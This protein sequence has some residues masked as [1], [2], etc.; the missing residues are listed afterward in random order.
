MVNLRHF[1]IAALGSVVAVLS[2]MVWYQHRQLELWRGTLNQ[3]TD[4]A[5]DAVA[6][7]PEPMEVG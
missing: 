7:R 4:R 3:A 5:D 2:V 1:V 6:D